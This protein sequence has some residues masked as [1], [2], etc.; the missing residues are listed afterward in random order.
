M[1][2]EIKFKEDIDWGRIGLL[3]KTGIIGALINLA[4]DLLAGWGIRDTS[5]TGIEG[6]VSQYLSMTDGRIFWSAMLGLVGAPIS[7][8]GHFG[9]YKLIKPYSRRY[10]KLYGVGMLGLL[11]LGGAG[12]H[13]SSLASAF[14]YKYMT[15]V[16]SETALELS[17][18]FAC[19][20]SLPLYMAFFVFWLIH[21]YAHIRAVA[22]GFS[23]YPRWCWVFSVPVGAFLFSLVG[24]F[25]NY[26]IVNAI[27]VGALTLGNIWTLGGS[28]LM[29]NKA[30]KTKANLYPADDAKFFKII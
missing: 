21:T 8:F 1:K 16:S 11:A 26:A 14:F 9:I 12:I 20:F 19:Y 3:I 13:M 18:K 7:V 23:P 4:G 22:G 28:L 17:I 15:A 27:M 10:A 5:L 6:A 2:E 29:L 30:R 24:I 25:G